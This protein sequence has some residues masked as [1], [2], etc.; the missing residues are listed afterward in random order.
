MFETMLNDVLAILR[1]TFLNGDWVSLMIAFGSVVAAALVM[2]R[3]TQIG[4]M[5]LLALS[6]FVIGGYLRGV[7]VGAAPEGGAVTSGRMASQLEAGW[8]AFMGLTAASLLAYFIAFMLIILV[9]FGAKT[10][11]GRQ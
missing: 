4:S 9:L 8:G 7:I 3:G 6:L 2:R 5:T 10:I 11:L 1:S